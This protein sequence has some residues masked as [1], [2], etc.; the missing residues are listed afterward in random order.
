MGARSADAD[1]HRA[2]AAVSFSADDGGIQRTGG[3]DGRKA[4]KKRRKS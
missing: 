3:G 1:F 2:C 4:E